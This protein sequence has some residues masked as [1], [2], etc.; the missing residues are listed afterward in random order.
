MCIR[1]SINSDYK[2]AQANQAV[3]SLLTPKE[4]GDGDTAQPA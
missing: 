4:D 3:L 2:R 1:D